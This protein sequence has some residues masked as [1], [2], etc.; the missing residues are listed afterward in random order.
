VFFCWDITITEDTPEDDPDTTWLSLPKGIVTKVDIKFPAGCH[1]MVRARLFQEALQLIPL[2]EDEWVTGDDET[3]TTETYAELLDS[4]YK[5]KL[6]TCSPD[7]VYPHTITV[8]IGVQP[9]HAAGVSSLT[10]MFRGF[11]EKLGM[12]Q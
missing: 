8:R 3:V 4:P 9:E 2:S 1:G 11:L 7:T 5:L 6:V 10:R 12:G